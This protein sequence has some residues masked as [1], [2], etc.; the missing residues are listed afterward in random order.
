[1]DNA[2]PPRR[3]YMT[4]EAA[5]SSKLDLLVCELMDKGWTPHGGVAVAVAAEM[6]GNCNNEWVYLQAMVCP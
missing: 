4:V 2:E 1:M 3:R 6:G 5:D